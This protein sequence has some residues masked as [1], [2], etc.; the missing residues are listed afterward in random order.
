MNLIKLTLVSI[1]G[2]MNRQQQEVIEYLQEEIRVL[3]EQQGGK[4]LRFT[5][6]QRARL[7]RKAKRI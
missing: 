7:A 4:R 2:W 5:D 6:D 3:K 1:A